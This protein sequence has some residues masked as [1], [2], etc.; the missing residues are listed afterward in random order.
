MPLYISRAQQVS[1]EWL[2]RACSP[3][4][5]LLS[6]GVFQ[7]IDVAVVPEDADAQ[8]GARD[9][10]VLRQDDEVGEEAAQGLQHACIETQNWYL[11]LK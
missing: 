2:L 10:A 4:H 11:I 9:K 3:T 8:Q 1:C 6:V 5:P 7:V